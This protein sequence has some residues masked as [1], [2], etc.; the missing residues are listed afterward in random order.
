V[1]ALVTAGGASRAT[2]C[3]DA[4]NPS[5]KTRLPPI[6]VNPSGSDN[7]VALARPPSVS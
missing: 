2:I 6:N 4:F 5:E 1:A 3:T 7:L